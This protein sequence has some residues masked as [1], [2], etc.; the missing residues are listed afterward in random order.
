MTEQIIDGSIIQ[1]Q[2]Y[3]QEQQERRKLLIRPETEDTTAERQFVGEK[4]MEII[5]NFPENVPLR[6]HGAHS[7]DLEEILKTGELSSGTDRAGISTSF[8]SS[9]E[10]SV[11]TPKTIRTTI[12]DYNKAL[13]LKAKGI[14]IT[15]AG[16]IDILDTQI[17]LGI[18][19]VL[20]PETQEE[21]ASGENGKDI[22]KNT[23]LKKSKM[24]R[25]LVSQEF[26]PIANK[27][28]IKYGYD[29][30]KCTTYNDFVKK[31]ST[32]TSEIKKDFPYIDTYK[33]PVAQQVFSISL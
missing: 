6:F 8:D 26:Q 12:G 11:T 21:A 16:Y 31:T 10:I 25:L 13:E 29:L 2:Q 9:G 23:D 7:F 30:N 4:F 19:F 28:L 18:I 33:P 5:G 1:L 22:M 20:M 15:Q 27:L 14:D 3:R 32:I 17:P 24:I